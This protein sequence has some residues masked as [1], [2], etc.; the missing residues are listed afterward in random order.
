MPP[1][2]QNRC[3]YCP[4]LRLV[5]IRNKMCLSPLWPVYV[6]HSIT[7][8]RS[9][10]PPHHLSTQVRFQGEHLSGQI[11]PKCSNWD[12]AKSADFWLFVSNLLNYKA[13]VCITLEGLLY[14]RR[15]QYTHKNLEKLLTLRHK[16]IMKVVKWSNLLSITGDL[17]WCVHPMSYCSA[18]N[19]TFSCPGYISETP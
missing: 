1:Q 15:P 7:D 14:F 10:W 11:T 12:F 16:K 6:K 3:I 18:P 2:I 5:S 4:P 17:C 9:D 13:V 8:R 19:K